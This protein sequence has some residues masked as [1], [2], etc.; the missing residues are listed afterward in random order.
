M[1]RK[2]KNTTGISD[3][4]INSIARALFP[5]IQEFL[6]IEKN[7]KEYEKWLLEQEIKNSELNK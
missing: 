3:F 1:S 5:S 2:R 4:V 6:S 7:Q